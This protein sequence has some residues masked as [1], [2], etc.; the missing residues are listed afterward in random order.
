[1]NNTKKLSDHAKI[2]H[3]SE[4]MVPLMLWLVTMHTYCRISV[5]KMRWKHFLPSTV[6]Y[7]KDGQKWKKYTAIKS[8]N[9][10]YLLLISNIRHILNSVSFLLC[11]SPASEFCM[12]LFWNTVCS[13]FRGM[14]LPTYE[15]GTVFSETLTY[16][17]QMPGNYPEGN[18]QNFILVSLWLYLPQW[19]QY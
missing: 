4:N 10:S 19:L 9:I 11:N 13:T 1:M 5:N 7:S 12:P 8:T 3:T 15:D 17:I 2:V 14:Y 16:K 6:I 18:I